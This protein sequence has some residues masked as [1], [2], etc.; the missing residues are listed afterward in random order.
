MK[1][2][3]KDERQLTYSDILKI[4]IYKMHVVYYFTIEKKQIQSKIKRLNV[5]QRD[6]LGYLKYDLKWWQL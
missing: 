6:P 5:I 4:L 3:E 1:Q 2:D